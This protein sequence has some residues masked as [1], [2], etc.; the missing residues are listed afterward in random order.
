M[1]LTASAAP[2]HVARRRAVIG[3]AGAAFIAFVLRLPFVWAGIGP[4][5]GGY[6]FIAHQWA[7]G[8]GLYH[9]VWVDRPQGLLILFRLITDVAYQAWAIRAAAVLAG[10]SITLLVGAI[11]WML[12]GPAT[13]AVAALV[14]AVVGVGPHIEGFTMNSELA[15]AVPAAAAVACAVR[16][17][18]LARPGWLV[19]AGLL[20]SVAILM[21][22]SGFDGLAMAL[23]VPL[24]TA[25]PVRDR[26][27]AV[28]FAAAGAAAPLVLAVIHGLSLGWSHYWFA[29]YGWR[30]HEEL[31]KTVGKRVDFFLGEMPRIGPDLLGISIVA[32]VGLAVCLL[33]RGLLWVIPLWFLVGFVAINVGGWYWPHYFVQVVPALALMAAVAVTAAEV[34]SRALAVALLCGAVVPVAVNL[35]HL[36]LTSSAGRLDGVPYKRGFEIDRRI[37]SFIRAHSTPRDTIYALASRADLYFLSRRNPP[38][39]YLWAHSPLQRKSVKQSLLAQ[40][41]APGGPKFIVE[42]RSVKS[43][44]KT[45]R[46]ERILRERYRFVYR[47]SGGGGKKTPAVLMA[48]DASLSSASTYTTQRPFPATPGTD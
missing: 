27:R 29:M 42:S 19:A 23:A 22:Q 12:R 48:R 10:V 35:A 5:E 38:V 33:R 26:L 30:A 25:A 31:G 8:F 32:L 17:R 44:D 21:K 41:A 4:D 7:N 6:A 1:R 20:G 40:F 2:L 34:R 13:G 24:L 15:A 47:P 39:P 14:F 16:W 37:A 36:A 9:G 46:A 45:G 28:G 18:V 11:G 43:L 3:I